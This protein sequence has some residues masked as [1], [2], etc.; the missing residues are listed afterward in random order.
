MTLIVLFDYFIHFRI[1]VHKESVGYSP[2]IFI[3]HFYHRMFYN[4]L[5]AL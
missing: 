2:L 4:V 5:C 3:S 1:Y